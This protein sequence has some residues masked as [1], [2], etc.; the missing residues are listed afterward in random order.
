[1]RALLCFGG[2]LFFSVSLSKAVNDCDYSYYD[3]IKNYLL[4]IPI[5]MTVARMIIVEVE[6]PVLLSLLASME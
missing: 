1:M 3:C 5:G 4:S 6:S 2:D